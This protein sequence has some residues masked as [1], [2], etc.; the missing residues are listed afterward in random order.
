VINIVSKDLDYYKNSGGGVTF[1]GGEPTMQPRF[2]LACLM[3]C[4]EIGIHTAIDTCGYVKW[5]VLKRMLPYVDLFLY[6]IKHMD[7][8]KHE[9]HTGVGNE[10]I[11]KNIRNIS[12]QGKPIWIRIPLIPGYNDSKENLHRI[13]EFVKPL[14][15]VEKVVL[16]PY[17]KAASAK[18]KFIGKKHELE[19][20][21]PHSKKKMEDFVEIFSCLGDV[22]VTANGDL[23]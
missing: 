7:A 12:Q 3:K 10:S 11:L 18:Y 6:D 2:L 14:M 23:S 22:I 16:L 20:L 19:D 8:A 9:E 21:V 5:S 1:S 15:S 4:K 17:N 13:A